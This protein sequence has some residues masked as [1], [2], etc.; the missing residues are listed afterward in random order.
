[1]LGECELYKYDFYDIIE[2]VVFYERKIKKK[3]LFFLFG[4]KMLY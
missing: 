4:K 2:Y 1:M 3:C